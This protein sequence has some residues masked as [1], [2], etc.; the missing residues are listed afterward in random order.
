MSWTEGEPGPDCKH[1]QCWDDCGDPDHH[2][3]TFVSQYEDGRY[4]LVCMWH[5][6]EGGLVIGPLPDDRPDNWEQFEMR[7]VA[8]LLNS[9][10]TDGKRWDEVQD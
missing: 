6:P 9:P 1:C 4:G 7:D 3:L 2:E 8:R 10:R 5:T